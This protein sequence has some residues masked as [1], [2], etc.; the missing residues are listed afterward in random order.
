[1]S[2]QPR[3]AQRP[4]LAWAAEVEHEQDAANLSAAEVLAA[5][6]EL[7]LFARHEEED[8]AAEDAAGTADEDANQPSGR[9]GSRQ[10]GGNASGEQQQRPSLEVLR[11]QFQGLVGEVQ[12]RVR[13]RQLLQV[14][15]W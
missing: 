14:G 4:L 15:G 5:F 3:S 11:R 7:L 1:M 10:Q 8:S 6:G 2:A 13:H 12:H 9:P